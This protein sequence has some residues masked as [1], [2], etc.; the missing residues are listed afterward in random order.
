MSLYLMQW[1]ILICQIILML[2]AITKPHCILLQIIHQPSIC[3]DISCLTK[4]GLTVLPASLPER[5][6]CL[7]YMTHFLK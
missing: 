5:K 1:V 2:F 3:M 7:S 6:P 4:S